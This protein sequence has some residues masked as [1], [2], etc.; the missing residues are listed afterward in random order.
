[1]ELDPWVFEKSGKGKNMIVKGAIHDYHLE[2]EDWENRYLEKYG[3]DSLDTVN[4][5]DPLHFYDYSE[6]EIREVIQEIK[7]AI[8]TDRPFE[9]ADEKV[10]K[11]MIF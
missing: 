10:Y 5:L 3:A 8:E 4:L 11:R 2:L 1:M 7:T 9:K 6:A